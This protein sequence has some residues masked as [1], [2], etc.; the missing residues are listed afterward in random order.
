M[1]KILLAFFVFTFVVYYSSKE[2]KAQGNS[3]VCFT[4][5]QALANAK[6]EEQRLVFTGI[7]LENQPFEL[8]ASSETYV[9]LILLPNG[10]KCTSTSLLGFTLSNK[11]GNP[12]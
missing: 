9:L 2:V 7:N 4:E 6:E 1:V 3:L 10:T 5:E 8:W 11:I 12:T